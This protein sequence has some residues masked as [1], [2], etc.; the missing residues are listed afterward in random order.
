M[1]LTYTLAVVAVKGWLFALP[2][3]LFATRTAPMLS[4]VAV[5]VCVVV[6]VVV[7]ITVL[8]AG[9]FDSPMA[10]STKRAMTTA[11][12]HTKLRNHKAGFSFVFSSWHVSLTH[13]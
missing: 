5:T 8:P 2:V 4:V 1:R 11:T 3:P 7:S 13:T 10:T 9:A 6:A 12:A